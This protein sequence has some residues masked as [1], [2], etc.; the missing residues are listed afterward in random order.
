MALPLANDNPE[1]ANP[2]SS[3]KS[4]VW[5]HFGY[6][7]ENRDGNRVVD[8]TQTICRKCF[9]KLTQVTGNTSNMSMHLQRHHP[10]INLGARKKTPAQK[11]TLPN[12]FQMKL[13]ANSDRAQKITRGIGSFMSLGMSPF[14]VVE[15][16]GFKHLISV[17]EPRY[18]LPSRAHF[19]QNVLPK[20]FE[21]TKAKVKEELNAAE[22]I[23]ITTDGWTSRGTQSYMTVTAHF[24]TEKWQ[25]ANPVL[26]TRIVYES[27]T[28]EH[29]AEILEAAVAEWKISK[30][31]APVPVTTDNAKNIANAVELAGFSP[32]VR[33]FAHTVNLAAQRGL[34]VQQVSRLLG[35][36]RK[37]VTFFHRSTTAA[38][39][40]KQKQELL[41]LPSHKLI[42]DVVT[43]WNSS[44]DMLE[45][46]LEQQAAIFSALTDKR[47]KKNVKD[48]VTLS[49]DDIKLAEALIQVVKPLKT[50]TTIMSTDQTPTVSM[51]IPLKHRILAS[52]K[53][54]ATDP[55]VVKEVKTAISRDFKDR[56]PDAD[57][58]LIQF[59]HLST[60][61]DPRFKSLPF[62]DESS[63]GDEIFKTLSDR[64][65]EDCSETVQVSLFE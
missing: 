39:M 17:L 32:H 5:E 60:A 24:I 19:S 42:Q 2:P 41:Q 45:R 26:Q 47:V 40:L 44:H 1:I 16:E 25:I 30:S 59:L 28:A 8:K 38:E 4:A 7:V 18:V 57:P 11:S 23:A 12:L 43:R 37:V 54:N 14:S 6:P 50:V 31:N 51:I 35:R 34:G 48:L 15:N 52:M 64:I 53:H 9:K 10:E 65:L 21:E 36:V 58:T 20:L 3:F 62:L 29:L 13:L 56:Y 61:L 46:Y 55:A 22:S 63:S 49:D 27:H 33:C